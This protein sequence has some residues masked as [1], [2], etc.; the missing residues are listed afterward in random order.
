MIRFNMKITRRR[1]LIVIIVAISIMVI[2]STIVKY[3]AFSNKEFPTL[4]YTLVSLSH[5]Q[6]FLSEQLLCSLDL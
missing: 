5:L 6:L 2:D 4:M 1:A 3:I